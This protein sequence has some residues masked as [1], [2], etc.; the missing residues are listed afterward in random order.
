MA[1]KKATKN[2]KKKVKKNQAAKPLSQKQGVKRAAVAK[3]SNRDST[4]S[5]E[6][7]VVSHNLM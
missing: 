6:G 1:T 5:S 2:S 7:E 4:M 3:D